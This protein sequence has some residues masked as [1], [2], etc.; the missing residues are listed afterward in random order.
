[1]LREREGPE[2]EYHGSR[3]ITELK[4]GF[5]MLG[6]KKK[7]TLDSLNVN[8]SADYAIIRS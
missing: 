1:V 8:I 4:S 6:I 7:N 2:E 5:T 3:T